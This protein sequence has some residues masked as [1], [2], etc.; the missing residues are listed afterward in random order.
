MVCYILIIGYSILLFMNPM[1]FKF[2]QVPT[3]LFYTFP[4]ASNSKRKEQNIT[5]LVRFKN[6]QR[7]E[8]LKKTLKTL[9]IVFYIYGSSEIRSPC[10]LPYAA[11]QHSRFMQHAARIIII[12]I[13]INRFV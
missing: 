11:T 12:I 2:L 3:V 13:I 9:K 1:N 8:N 10:G 7:L 6:K 5:A 4:T